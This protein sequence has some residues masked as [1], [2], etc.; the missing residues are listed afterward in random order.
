MWRVGLLMNVA[1]ALTL[2]RVVLTPFFVA[3]LF[4]EGM[5]SRYGASLIF[6]CAA[7]SDFYDGYVARKG[8]A[9]T[10]FGRFMDPL[11]D[12]ILTSA[13]FISFAMLKI[14]AAW[15]VYVMVAREVMVTGLRVYSI[16]RKNPLITS[17]F[18]KWKTSCQMAVIFFILVLLTIDATTAASGG[19]GGVLQQT[20]SSW[21]L[22]GLVFGVTVL[23]V[24]TG[25]HYIVQNLVFSRRPLRE[26]RR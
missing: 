10:K 1:N 6:L 20:W 5:W 14:V 9:V 3:L 7:L 8:G 24:A 25:I 26:G 11:A 17:R 13:A 18:A 21:V 22:N 15:M 23:V 4:R 12:K 19:Q 16:S 2:F